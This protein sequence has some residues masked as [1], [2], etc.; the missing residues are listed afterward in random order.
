LFFVDQNTSYPTF[1]DAFKGAEIKGMKPANRQTHPVQ[2]S[3]KI[4]GQRTLGLMPKPV[5][6]K[7]VFD[8]GNVV[9]N[10]IDINNNNNRKSST[11]PKLENTRSSGKATLEST[12]PLP[13]T[14]FGKARQL[15]LTLNQNE[16]VPGET[17]S[18]TMDLIVSTAFPLKIIVLTLQCI[19]RSFDGVM[20]FPSTMTYCTKQKSVF[21]YNMYKATETTKPALGTLHFSFQLQIPSTAQTSLYY[22]DLCYI[23]YE[24]QAH[25]ISFSSDIPKILSDDLMVDIYAVSREQWKNIPTKPISS[26]KDLHKGKILV[27]FTLNSKKV[28]MGENIEPVLK[29]MNKTKKI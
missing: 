22:K 6:E 24:L 5:I 15:K 28:L 10:K 11:P 4:Q 2:G 14:A 18:G 25:A 8:E 1:E 20:A 19:T 17:I 21:Q 26:E 27:T 29:V 12:S 13:S 9:P 23:Y 16:V 3:Q 7:D